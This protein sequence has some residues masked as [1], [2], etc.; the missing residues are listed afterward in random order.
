MLSR[1]SLSLEG[2]QV[3]TYSKV[4]DLTLTWIALRVPAFSLLCQQR[5]L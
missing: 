1:N 5:G 4:W 2:V 3:F